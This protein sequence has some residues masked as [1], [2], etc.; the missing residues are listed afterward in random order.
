V[1]GGSSRKEK[2]AEN[3]SSLKMRGNVSQ[4]ILIFPQKTEKTGLC[5]E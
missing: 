1:Q 3:S 5:Y 4:D 2:Q